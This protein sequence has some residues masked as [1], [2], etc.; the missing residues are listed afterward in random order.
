MNECRIG[1][2]QNSKT[3]WLKPLSTIPNFIPLAKARVNSKFY[4]I[5]ELLKNQIIKNRIYEVKNSSILW[6][7]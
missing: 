2:S 5:P 1:F 6:F 7:S 4:V 3:F